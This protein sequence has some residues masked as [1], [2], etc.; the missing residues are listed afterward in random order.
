MSLK[1]PGVGKALDNYSYSVALDNGGDNILVAIKYKI[2]NRYGVEKQT[3]K[4][5][6]IR[7]DMRWKNPEMILS[8]VKNHLENGLQKEKVIVR[9]DKPREYIW[10]KDDQFTGN[11]VLI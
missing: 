2:V 1:L 11:S 10:F 6:E 3:Y 8:T 7:P 4:L 5:F 9:E